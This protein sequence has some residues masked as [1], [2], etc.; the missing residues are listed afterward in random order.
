MPAPS[1]NNYTRQGDTY[2]ANTS[3]AGGDFPATMVGALRR[4]YDGVQT[5]TLTGT[6]QT[7]T[8]PSTA[9]HADVYCAG[10]AS[11]DFARYWHGGTAPTASVGM[12]LKDG[13]LLETGDPDSLKAIIGSG[14]PVL[15]AEFYHYA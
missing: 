11:T 12:K 9:T 14:S 10:G 15:S 7:L 6:A 8:V 4:V 3:P 13:E 5:L 1:S 2:R